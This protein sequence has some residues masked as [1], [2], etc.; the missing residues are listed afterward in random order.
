MVQNKVCWHGFGVVVANIMDKESSGAKCTGLI[1]DP[2][3]SSTIDDRRCLS[4]SPLRTSNKMVTTINSL[5]YIHL[6]VSNHN[7]EEMENKH[8]G[9]GAPFSPSRR[10][11]RKKS[12]NMKY[13][14]QIRF[15]GRGFFAY[16]NWD[17]VRG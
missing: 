11:R 14:A 13:Y 6:C 7:T 15:K 17:N 16:E 2:N 5:I 1:R 3:Q 4:G 9:A 12:L 8:E 10:R